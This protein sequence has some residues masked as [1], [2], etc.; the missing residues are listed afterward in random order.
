MYIKCVFVFIFGFWGSRL[1]VREQIRAYQN[2]YM[3][4]YVTVTTNQLDLIGSDLII[5]VISQSR[6]IENVAILL[7]NISDCFEHR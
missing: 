3:L 6:I 7:E 1:G 5:V 2:M 4:D